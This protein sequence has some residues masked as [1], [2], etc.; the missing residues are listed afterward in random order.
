MTEKEHLKEE[1]STSSQ[2]EEEDEDDKNSL[3]HRFKRLIGWE[4]PS[5][6]EHTDIESVVKYIR[7]GQCKNIITM[8]G[9]GMSTSAGIPDFRSPGSGLYENLAAY[10][11]PYPTAI[12]EL[13]YFHKNPEP[14]FV[15]AKNLFPSEL[16]PTVSH[17]FIK[18][19]EEKGL[20]L[21]HYTQNI[22]TLER[23]AGL[24]EKKLVEAHGTFST[25]HCVKC[26]A[27]YNLAWLRA[28]ILSE[29]VPKCE[30]GGCDGVVKPDVILFGQ[31]LPARFFTN[32]FMDFSRCDL[33][34]ILGTSLHVQPFASLANKV[35]KRTPRLY[36]NLEDP[37]SSS[38]GSG[39]L[40]SLMGLGVSFRAGCTGNTRDVF[41]KGTCDEGSFLL[42]EKLGWKDDLAKLVKAG[43][44]FVFGK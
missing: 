22:D 8:A 9:A 15:L 12:F 40:M 43:K 32:I 6:L 19:I 21:R 14:F 39:F 37:P 18:L 2:C 16:K 41:W 28:K 3:A 30:R 33:L 5:L 31:S 10:N 35:S 27:L 36:I 29:T 17:Y 20:L 26:K 44:P 4:K 13:S 42:A 25:G 11:L 23:I 24:G 7:S 38:Y 1:P 34:I